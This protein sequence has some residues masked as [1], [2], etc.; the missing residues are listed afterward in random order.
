MWT[1]LRRTAFTGII[2]IGGAAAAAAQTPATGATRGPGVYPG[3]PGEN[4]AP[5]MRLDTTTYRNLARHRPAFHSSSYDYNLTAQLVTDGI[6]DTA[7]PRWIVTAVGQSGVISQDV[8]SLPRDVAGEVPSGFW[9]GQGVL[10]RHKRE[11]FL[12]GNWVTGVDLRGARGWVQVEVHG[13]DAPP[14]ISGLEVV[15]SVDAPGQGPE[16][17][18]CTA[19]GSNDGRTWDTLGVTSGM[20]HRGTDFAPAIAFRQ[21]SRNRYY[22]VAFDNPRAISW[23]VGEVRLSHAGRPVA[24]AGPHYFSSAWKSLGTGEEWV[25][26]DLGGVCTFDRV[27]LHWIAG[28]AAGSLQVSDDASV[29]RTLRALPAPSTDPDDLRLAAPARARYVRVL[30]TKPASEAGYVLSEFEI[31]GRGGPVPDPQPQPA[32]R[33]D[34]RLDLTRGR[35]RVQRDSLVTAGASAISTAGFGD[36]AWVVATVPGTILASY[37]NAGAV[38]DPNVGDNQLMISDA[39]FHADFWYRTEFEAGPVDDG[40][41]WL[42]VD[43]I[44]WNAEV[45][46]NGERLGRIRGGFART[47][48]DVTGRLRAGGPNALAVRIEKQA[49]P[50]SVKEK[51]FDHPD[52]NGGV[53][54]ADNPTFHASI[55]WDWIPTIRGRNTG[56]WND[57]YLTVTGPVTVG[58]PQVTTT[59]PLPATSSADVRMSA[60]VQN[61]GSDPVSGTFRARFGDVTVAVP[62]QLAGGESRVVTVDPATHP[63]LR[64]AS[65]RLWW[66][67]GYGDPHLYDAGVAFDTAP[68]TTSDAKTFKAGVRQFT[69]SFQGNTLRMWINGRRFVPRGGNW[70]FSESMLRYRAREYDA[71]V[72]YHRDMHFTMIRNWVGQTGDDEFYDACDR[73][74]IVVWQDFWLANPWDGPDPQDDRVFMDNAA[75]LV[76]AIRTH[77]SVGLY[78]GRNEGYPPKPLDDAIRALLAERHPDVPYI[79]SSADDVASGHGP[80]Q[81]M[82]IPYYFLERATPKIHGEMGMP[83][84]VTMDS[85]RLMMPAEARWP[86]G[87]MYGLHDFCMDGAQGGRSFLARMQKSYG[88]V[89]N[90]EDWVALA[91]FVN[92]EGYRAMFEA[93]SRNRMGLLLWMSHPAWPS[94]VWQ[95]YDYYLDPTAAYFGAKAASE[96]LHI[97]WNPTT[98]AVEVVNYHAGQMEGLTATARV[99]NLDGSVQWERS[100]PLDSTEDSTASVIDL[101]Y[102]LTVSAVHFVSLELR[103]GTDIL[104]K[105]LYWRGIEEGNYQALRR[106]PK[107]QINAATQVVQEG[108]T[109]RL[110]TDLHNPSG[111][112]ALMVRVKVVRDTSGDRIL[113]ALYSDNYITLMP[114]ERRTVSTEVRVADARGERPRMMVEGFNVAAR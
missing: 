16:N 64:L 4:P 8:R 70:G 72:R 12:D 74:G 48:F 17:W 45:Y 22:R 13:G 110:T 96:P 37:V 106:L 39:F 98:E 94:L 101:E 67:N 86:L 79:S 50:G 38:P 7:A 59:L 113:P 69:F 9:R 36:A 54:G 55:G 58:H 14:A 57:V 61:H 56:I 90:V 84:I 31:F 27:V 114:G 83:S 75:D 30:M 97:Q 18:T 111:T 95:T 81:A 6:V 47:R 104:S 63:A 107:I 109:W 21:V 5:V 73:Y 10:P 19:L 23:R 112:P 46:L 105:N 78:C 1:L 80:Y 108:T 66:P 87:P 68:G 41:Q 32:R 51:T 43:G 2:A 3:D 71:A 89:D 92:Y 85:L 93:Q 28:P 40:R 44:N 20:T 52:L 88:P 60:T 82:P 26:V 11:A 42:N 29:W 62:V 102:P 103:R 65:P 15:A 24:L 77:P 49:S 25:S 100:A 35:W 99:L 76:S 34:G 91:Q 33:A 53:L